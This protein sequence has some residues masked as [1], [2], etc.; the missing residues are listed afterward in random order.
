MKLPPIYVTRPVLPEL[1]DLL[2]LLETIWENRVLTNGGPLLQRFEA[3][4]CDYLGVEYLSLVANATLGTVLAMQHAGLT[5]G[6]VL[7]LIHI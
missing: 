1:T 7:S 3:A 5:S 4:L 6:E 2:P